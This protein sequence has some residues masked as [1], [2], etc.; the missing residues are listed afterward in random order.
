[1]GDPKGFLKKKR[2]LAEYRPVCERIKD[3]SEVTIPRTP[4]HAVDQAS[5]CMDCGTP[6]CHWACPLGN[7][8]PEWNHLMFKGRWKEAFQTLAFS[9][10]LPEITGRVCPAPCEWS[11]VLGIN[12]DS[13]TIRENELSIIEKAFDE[14]LVP[15][16]N[17]SRRYGEAIA[18]VGSG[19]AGLSCASFL[20]R[21]GY[22]VTVFERDE[23]PGG[24]LRFGIPDFKLEKRIID[25]R[26]EIMRQE[27]VVFKCSTE[28]GEDVSL[29][30]LKNKFSLVCL[31]S[32]CRVPRDLDIE[33]RGLDGIHFAMD[34]LTQSNRR[35]RGEI[36]PESQRIDAEG[37]SVV[38]IGG[39]DTGSDC[40]GTANR[41]G[42]KCVVQV[43]VLPRPSEHRTEE[44][45]WPVYPFLLKTSSSHEEGVK[46]KWSVLTKRFAGKDGRVEKIICQKTELGKGEGESSR[47]ICPIG[48]SEF[49]IEADLVILAIGFT[50]PENGLFSGSDTC[51]LDGRGNFKTDKNYLTSDPFVYAAGDARRGQ[52]LVVW[53]IS[54][55]MQAAN[56]MHR[57]LREARR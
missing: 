35:V 54:E 27:G 50:K 34:Y 47:T 17:I 51:K 45:P 48:G 52:S 40:V 2:V 19:P 7:Y 30:D 12:D 22:A 53:A 43:E 4:E 1:M 13:V 11:C 18:V 24:L 28:V 25:R 21:A 5:R 3:Y 44:C 39:G 49:E 16:K 41:Q 46:R 36:I 31:T 42:A 10:I 9:N 37:K 57:R 26:L 14:G 55:G 6:F 38:I 8:V 32:G 20:A 15:S 56:A 33:G 23:E 29:V